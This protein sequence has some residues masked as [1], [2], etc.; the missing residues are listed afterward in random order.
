MGTDTSEG[1]VD[2]DSSGVTGDTS[3][4]D[5]GK[6]VALSQT[7]GSGSDSGDVETFFDPKSIEG[8]PELEAAYKQMLGDYT[9]KMQQ[10]SEGKTKVEQYDAFIAN[11]L[12]TMQQLATE[13]GWTLIEGAAP[14]QGNGEFQPNTWGD[15]EKHLLDKARTE[16]RKEF[17]PLTN[18]VKDLKRQNV[19]T[20][21]D[22]D[23]PDWR[24]YESEMSDV[25]QRHPTLVND[26]DSLYAMSVPKEILEQ[27]SMKAALEKVKGGTESAKISGNKTT[28]I[29]TTDQPTK[30]LSF[31]EAVAFAKKKLG[32]SGFTAPVG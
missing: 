26:V 16:L 7:T 11:P 9:K 14:N 21:L 10:F 18:E 32:Y 3:D 13:R 25:L 31:D 19:E 4:A 22:R 5:G 28:S 17:A 23:H 24:A 12:L 8:K 1:Q 27:R 6:S 30:P 29:P 2:T 15:V 20:Q